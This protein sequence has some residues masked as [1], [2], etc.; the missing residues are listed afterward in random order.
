MCVCV[1]VCVCAGACAF[2]CV[3]ARMCVCVF[4]CVG[5]R[6]CV[7]VCVCLA[8]VSVLWAF[9]VLGFLLGALGVQGIDFMA[10]RQIAFHISCSRAKSISDLVLHHTLQGVVM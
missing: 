6:D 4:V 8:L 3:C 5:V 7:L 2:M 10:V 1:G 9:L